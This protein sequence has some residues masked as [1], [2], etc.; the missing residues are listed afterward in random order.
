LS[1]KLLTESTLHT[2]YQS[3]LQYIRSLQTVNQYM[4]AANN[5]LRLSENAYNVLYCMSY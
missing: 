3:I 4:C 2:I 1:F 5:V